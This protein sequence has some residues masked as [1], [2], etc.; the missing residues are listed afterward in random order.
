MENSCR[1]RGTELLCGKGSCSDMIIAEV[2]FFR[3]REVD[4]MIIV[5]NFY[6]ELLVPLWGLMAPFV[7]KCFSFPKRF[8]IFIDHF[9]INER[10]HLAHRYF[11]SIDVNLGVF[12]LYY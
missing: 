6:H 1:F 3:N 4:C 8:L 11:I 9:K 10:I 2:V 7:R 12:D 5:L